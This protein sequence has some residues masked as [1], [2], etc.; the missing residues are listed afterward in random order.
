MMLTSAHY[1]N[2]GSKGQ[3]LKA[4]E[5][6]VSEPSAC[7]TRLPTSNMQPLVACQTFLYNS[8]HYIYFVK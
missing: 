7:G 2:P 1:T 6:F 5:N 8:A 4:D 3:F